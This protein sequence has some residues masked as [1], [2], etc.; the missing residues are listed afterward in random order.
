MNYK[1]NRHF[2][3]GHV[4]FG[5]K[6]EL[7]ILATFVENYS[8]NNSK[9]M[10]LRGAVGIGKSY[11][12]HYY[13]ANLASKN[14][15][16]TT[17]FY[18]GYEAKTPYGPLIEI[19]SNAFD[20]LASSCFVEFKSGLHRLKSQLDDGQLDQFMNVFP[21]LRVYL[22]SPVSEDYMV[23]K[24]DIN[25]LL[26]ILLRI[27]EDV[28]YEA[29]KKIIFFLDD[30]HSMDKQSISFIEEWLAKSLNDRIVWIAAVVDDLDVSDF[31]S[32]TIIPNVPKD[33]IELGGL[34]SAEIKELIVYQH[35]LVLNR[36]DSFVELISQITKGNPL[37]IKL[38]IPALIDVQVLFQDVNTGLWDYD[39]QHIQKIDKS[40]K[41]VNYIL[42]KLTLLPSNYLEILSA[43][44][45]IGYQF[46]TAILAVIL[47]VEQSDLRE[48]L[49]ICSE[50]L[51]IERI[52]NQ[53]MK[54]VSS[55]RFIHEMIRQAA[56]ESMT[57][58]KRKKNHYAIG[59]T[60]LAS[61]GYAARE[62]HI[63]DIVDQFNKCVTYFSTEKDR[64]ELVEMN[65]QAGKKAKTEDYFDFAQDYFTAAIR[66]IEG[67]RQVWEKEL[68]F[69]VYIE[70]G[71]V[72][73]LKNDYVSS[74]M[75]FE[76][77]LKYA[78]NPI[79]EAKVHYQFLVMQTAVG[80]LAEAWNSGLKILSL[81]GK[82]LP[83]IKRNYQIIPEYLK[84]RFFF[85]HLK[86]NRS[87]QFEE[88]T[89]P[90]AHIL[91]TTYMELMPSI[92]NRELRLV[93][94]SRSLD[95]CRKNGISPASFFAFNGLGH[96]V[97]VELRQV[98]KGWD[99]FQFS[100]NLVNKYTSSRFK[101][102]SQ[103]IMHS[104]YSYFLE[105]ISKEIPQ[106]ELVAEMATA[107]GDH[108]T[109]IATKLQLLE[110][111][112]FN[113]EQL[114]QFQKNIR[115]T[116]PF[117]RKTA[118]PEAQTV[119]KSY[120]LLGQILIHGYE[121]NREL[122]REHE[123]EMDT[124]ENASFVYV[125]EVCCLFTSVIC[126]SM[127]K[128][129][130][131][132]A[133]MNK[134]QVSVRTVSQIIKNTCELFILREQV[135]TG[136]NKNQAINRLKSLRREMSQKARVNPSNFAFPHLLALGVLAELRGNYENAYLEYRGALAAAEK[137]E[138][139]HF[140]GMILERIAHVFSN[141]NRLEEAKVE[142]ENSKKAYLS[143]GAHF[144]V[145][146]IEKDLQKFVR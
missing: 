82:N 136:Q 133:D 49:R 75:F 45:T 66:L 22:N 3:E 8:R 123:R 33:A 80:D 55:Y 77:A 93:I 34:G 110:L 114:D 15:L 17:V 56:Y 35:P 62:R 137:F 67:N 143:W 126:G 63:Y 44:A 81:I 78:V 26:R 38:L 5:R 68:V 112:L 16:Y 94:L 30:L 113:G 1:Q 144:K 6:R 91:L 36:D 54:G 20:L 124:V 135:L 57:K 146:L 72:A 121:S 69:D 108:A 64:L 31:L 140:K 111:G 97:G 73:Y 128:C 65:L 96:F 142:L 23:D 87:E 14:T 47:Q 132:L 13:A 7:D 74:V 103:L 42:S 18:S 4:L 59:K 2:D 46:N 43:A 106:L 99:L 10:L 84:L 27:I 32:S 127:D 41:A 12:V 60:Y 48:C 104:E 21:R 116:Y 58:E 120:D 19:C 53:E 40:N 102:R 83:S 50:Q 52:P 88:L 105:S 85:A 89:D 61:L 129:Y 90:I 119:L 79:Q 109:V 115:S 98:R 101:A 28:V 122:I 95:I 11:L 100:D 29:K 51:L 125:W 145:A 141:Q 39:L 24:K 92:Q 139:H 138:F 76:S 70:S 86:W 118:N 131:V 37:E 107:A 117:V 134:K 130:L 9:L 25:N 71:E